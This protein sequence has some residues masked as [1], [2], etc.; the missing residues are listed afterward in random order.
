MAGGVGG[1]VVR[2][3]EPGDFW[4]V[5][6]LYYGFYREVDGD[7]ARLGVEVGLTLEERPPS[8]ADEFAWFAEKLRALERGDAVFK[9]AE[10]GE[11]LVGTCEIARSRRRGFS[12][13]GVLGIAVAREWRGRGVGRALA[14]A[15]IRDACGR[16]LFELIVLEVMDVN[17]R[18]VRLYEKLGFVKYGYLPK[19]ARLRGRYF[20]IVYMYKEC[21]SGEPR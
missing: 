16:R 6:E 13:V 5:V 4:Q 1:V 12:H 19:G 11:R 17:E 8:I 10:V 21:G 3:L 9:V 20:N 14:E 18:A 2:D 15:A 7:P